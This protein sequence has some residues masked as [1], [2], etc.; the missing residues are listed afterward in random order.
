MLL[1]VEGVV[2]EDVRIDALRHELL[3][4]ARPRCNSRRRCPEC[5]ARCPKY[6]RGDGPRRWRALNLESETTCVEA[7]AGRVKYA[8]HGVRAA[9]VKWARPGSALTRGF[10]D[11]VAWLVTRTS[12]STVCEL[13]GITW[14][15]VGAIIE[16]TLDEVWRGRDPFAGRRASALTR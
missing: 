16:R 6:D 15:T 13:L 10:E 12:K 7:D 3:I 8:R 14:H 11:Q 5:G 4:V 1:G 9:W 2:V